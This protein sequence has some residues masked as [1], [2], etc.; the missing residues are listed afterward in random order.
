[1]KGLW[2]VIQIS[3]DIFKRRR[4]ENLLKFLILKFLGHGKCFFHSYLSFNHYM[5]LCNVA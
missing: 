1:M 4:R 5:L 3:V 2:E